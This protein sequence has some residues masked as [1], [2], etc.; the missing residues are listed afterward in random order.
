MGRSSTMD[1]NT[2]VDFTRPIRRG[3]LRL[4]RE[5][6]QPGRT[7]SEQ[8][9][10]RRT[11]RGLRKTTTDTEVVQESPLGGLPGSNSQD[12]RK[13]KYGA[14]AENIASVLSR[15]RNAF[16]G[17]DDFV[18]TLSA[19]PKIDAYDVRGTF[20]RANATLEEK[21]VWTPEWRMPGDSRMPTQDYQW[22]SEDA[23]DS[24]FYDEWEDWMDL[25]DQSFWPQSP[26]PSFDPSLPLQVS[27]K[28]IGSWDHSASL[29]TTPLDLGRPA[30]GS[31]GALS[32][33]EALTSGKKQVESPKETLA[34]RESGRDYFVGRYS[35]LDR[36]PSQNWLCLRTALPPL[37]G[38]SADYRTP[39]RCAWLQG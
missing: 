28:D 1:V 32:V 31:D 33:R 3:D 10:P 20:L 11:D 36:L 23:E 17:S 6:R 18:S 7:A 25:R 2:K 35:L 26:A 15:S 9:G 39:V 13:Q 22:L 34:F 24:F 8:E 5:D 4:L 27:L 19:W 21:G 30:I 16:S 14:S 29:E 37:V 38:G 12:R